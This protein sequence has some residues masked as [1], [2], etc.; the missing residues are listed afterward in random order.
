MSSD[1]PRR[2][3]NGTLSHT[4]P[5]PHDGHLAPRLVGGRRRHRGTAKQLSPIVQGQIVHL[6]TKRNRNPHPTIP[7]AA[8]Y[9]NCARRWL[10]PASFARFRVGKPTDIL[11]WSRSNC[12]MLKKSASFVLACPSRLS[13]AKRTLRLFVAAAL[14]DD[15]FEHPAPTIN[16]RPSHKEHKPCCRPKAMPR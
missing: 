10:T 16:A 14:L 15:L 13:V 5:H 3:G 9:N 1:R 2:L 12:R 11:I 6:P 8:R 7:L 4:R